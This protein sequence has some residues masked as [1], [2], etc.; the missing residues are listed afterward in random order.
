MYKICKF[1][2]LIIS[3][4][5]CST[6]QETLAAN[7]PTVIFYDPLYWESADWV[8]KDLELLKEFGIFHDSAISAA[9]HINKIWNNVESWWNEKELQNVRKIWCRKYAYKN[10]YSILKL[11]KHLK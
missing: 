1:N 2:R 8:K 7:I 3:T 10:N 9:N 11:N 4:Y 6:Y 5:N